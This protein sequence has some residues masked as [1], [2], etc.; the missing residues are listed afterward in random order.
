MRTKLKLCVAA[1]LTA[2]SAL[3]MAGTAAA[4]E[5]GAFAAGDP[6]TTNIP[7]VAWAGEE[8]RLVKC[9]P[10]TITGNAEW[11]VVSNSIDEPDGDNR[12][13][14]FF[15][16]V[17]RITSPFSGAGDQSGRT[18]WAIDVESVYPGMARI[19]MAVD[20]TN[21]EGMPTLKHDFLVIWLDMSN[22]TLTELGD[23]AFPGFGVGDPDGDGVFVPS[24]GDY[25]NGL[26]RITVTGEF[27]DLHGNTRTLPDDWAALAE[28]YAADTD[29]YNPARWD[30]HD[31]ELP[32][33]PHTSASI[34]GG[35]A[36]IDAVDNCLGGTEI[37]AFSRLIGG[38]SPTAGPFDP[39]RPGSSFLPDGKLDAGDAPM[40]AARIDVRLSGTVDALEDADKHVLYS[41][42][43]TGVGGTGGIPA[44][45]AHNLYAPFYA[46][47][48]PA[49]RA[50]QTSSGTHGAVANN[51]PG[52]QNTEGLYHFWDLL[53]TRSLPGGSNACR[54]VG[55]DGQFGDGTFIPRPAGFDRATVYT[56]EHGE[57]IVSFN[58]DVG[59]R[60]TPDDQGLCDLGDSPE[61]E[62][63]G[64][65]VITAEARDPFQL[66]FERRPGNSLT[67]N[68]FEL[69]YK[70]LDCYPKNNIE[71]VCI[72]TIVDI[73]GNPVEGAPVLFSAE[74]EGTPSVIGLSG[75]WNTFAGNEC[76]AVEREDYD[77][78]GQLCLTN[79]DGQ[80]GVIVR[81][82]LD[83]LVDVIA[84]NYATRNIGFGVMRDR[85]IDFNASDGP[86]PTDGPSCSMPN[87][88]GPVIPPAPPVGGGGGGGGTVAQS[89]PVATVVSL[90]GAA[91][92]AKAAPVAK[93]KVKAAKKA[94]KLVSARLVVVKGKRHLVVRANGSAKTAKI[95]IT[96]VM[97]TGK[98]AKPVVRTI[99]TNKA[100]RVANL[101]VDRHVRTVR[102]AL[103]R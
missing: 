41:R 58:P 54:D 61:P 34:C 103:A 17:D 56:D 75:P 73:R 80:A 57:A 72:E 55:G 93:A 42:N 7:Y 32:T 33:V 13:P 22:P 46:A 81:T 62:L 49:T 31:D 98:V 19:K 102:V 52:Y 74:S 12:D 76:E 9:A 27:E 10:G 1:S 37:G 70:S 30:I 16:D 51:F 89:A 69:A 71:A 48:I 91:V 64:S 40:P 18:C 97:R 35:A 4:G 5:D 96:L 29:D 63:L 44:N 20:G 79:E 85:C 67:K 47:Y 82:T 45:N 36:A 43:R 2:L 95:R 88:P 66:T 90:A 50:P 8:I 38:T 99:R 25:L 83:T 24:D 86:L 23:D 100:V 39:V 84:E 26:V 59:A 65:A 3:A 78:D 60:L 92:P 87:A 68:V 14:V 15:D 11:N 28:L 94:T 53:N 21:P 101:R 6:L 77:V